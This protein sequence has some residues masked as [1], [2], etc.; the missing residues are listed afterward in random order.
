MSFE[1]PH[2]AEPETK[3]WMQVICRQAISESRF[4]EGSVVSQ[5]MSDV[6]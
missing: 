5:T 3:P 4:E 2:R 1:F 6:Q